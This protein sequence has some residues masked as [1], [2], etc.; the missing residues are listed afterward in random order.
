M[1]P[2]QVNDLLVHEPLAH[3]DFVGLQGDEFLFLESPRQADAVLVHL[4]HPVN[5]DMALDAPGELDAGN[6]G[7]AFSFPPMARSMSLPTRLP[8]TSL[9]GSPWIWLKKNSPHYM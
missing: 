5:G 2:L 8:S 7:R 9:M 3:V 4:R 1:E 6:P